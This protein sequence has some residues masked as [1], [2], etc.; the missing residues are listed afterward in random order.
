MSARVRPAK[1]LSRADNDRYVAAIEAK[2]RDLG[3]KDEAIAELRK[4]A[5]TSESAKVEDVKPRFQETLEARIK[6]VKDAGQDVEFTLPIEV[7]LRHVHFSAKAEVGKKPELR[8]V[9]NAN[10][11]GKIATRLRRAAGP[12][13]ELR[14]KHMLHDVSASFRPGSLTLVLGPPQ[15]GKTSLLRLC[16]GLLKPA[17]NAT[18]AAEEV[19]FNGDPVYPKITGGEK[20]FVPTKVSSYVDQIDRHAPSLTVEETLIFAWHTL[21]AKHHVNLPDRVP[22]VDD[23]FNPRARELNAGTVKPPK[24]DFVLNLLGIEHVR[25]TI[26]GNAVVRGVSGGQR[27]RVTIGEMFMGTARVLL[28]DE[29]STGLDSQT[30]FE[31]IRSFRLIADNFRSTMILS[32]LQPPPEVFNL[33]D[34]VALLWDGRVVY[35]GPTDNVVAH[36]EAIGYG[37]P[38]RKDVSDYLIEICSAVGGDYATSSNA[39][40]TPQALEDAWR[41]TPGHAVVAARL[42]T[43]PDKVDEWPEHFAKRFELP[44]QTYA[45]W[46]F[47][48]RLMEI[49]GDPSYYKA[50]A[51]Q[52]TF[53][54]LFTGS[55]YF[56]TSYDDFNN[57][58]G[59]FFVALLYIGLGAVSEVPGNIETRNMLYKHADQS[60]YPP[61]AYALAHVSFRVP[62]VVVESLVY[63]NLL[64]WLIGLTPGGYIGFFVIV[65]LLGLATSSIFNCVSLLAPNAAVATPI[66]GLCVLFFVLFSGF[67]V[68]EPAIPDGWIWM[69]WISPVAWAFR[70]VAVNEF[71]QDLYKGK[72]V[73]QEKGVCPPGSGR[74]CPYGSDG[75]FFLNAYGIKTERVWFY[76]GIIALA[77]YFVFFFALYVFLAARIRHNPAPQLQLSEYD[78]PLE[79]M[80]QTLTEEESSS[81]RRASSTISY[82]PTTLAFKNVKYTVMV[83]KERG[84]PYPLDLLQ[85]VTG[86][87]KPATLTALMGSSGAGKTTLLDVIAGRKTGGV[88]E[89]EITINGH[90]KDQKTFTRISGYVEQLDVHSPES[91]VYEATLFSATLR[92]DPKHAAKTRQF[93]DQIVSVLE[94]DDVRDRQIGALGDGD[95]LSFEQRKRLT[96]AVELAA[97]PAILFLDEP[98]SGLDS[99]AAIVVAR[100]VQSI[101][102]TGRSVICTIHQ[103]SYAL[104]SIFDRL[105]L[106]KKGGQTVYFGELGRECGDLTAYLSRACDDLATKAMRHELDDGVNPATWMLSACVAPEDFAAYYGA[107]ELAAE[108]VKL[109]AAAAEKAPGSEPVHFATLYALPFWNQVRVLTRRQ[110][111]NY[112]RSPSYNVTRGMVT[113]IV[114]VIFGTTFLKPR[115]G[116]VH[117]FSNSFSRCGLMY[118]DVFFMGIIFYSSAIPNM[119]SQRDSYYREYASRMYA[120]LPYAITFGIAEF[121]YLVLYSVLHVGL[122]WA[123][124]DFF[125]ANDGFLWYLFFF[126]LFISLL[127][128]MAQF[129]AAAMPNQQVASSLGMASR[130]GGGI[131]A[132]VSAD[133]LRRSDLSRRLDC[134]RGGR[135]ATDGTSFT[136]VVRPGT[137]PSRP[138]SR[139]S[140]SRPTTS[141]ASGA[142]CT[143]SRRSTTSSRASS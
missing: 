125:P 40:A 68:Q 66:S 17:G 3:V 58:L 22:G 76:Y 87:A 119:V 24:L 98:T 109:T 96:M 11:L 110:V 5:E 78:A 9:A 20:R 130:G 57:K 127:T 102:S 31:I 136:D 128:Y 54:G 75:A 106:L 4:T 126:F 42:A 117:D 115:P 77:S 14:D 135:T 111:T 83:S 30:T 94:L 93:V 121:P 19:S 56:N 81:K 120:A 88:V 134:S 28:G 29:I 25:D 45:Y 100:A 137:S 123:M 99:R 13:P 103:P 36:L 2:L 129:L 73:Y 85:G 35:H 27:R 6:A 49:K 79:E 113:I 59:A 53:M 74:S 55:L 48:R 105:L 122:L 141:P 51:I 92:L 118:L 41:A 12:A 69:Y 65:T 101:S 82:E 26:V 131:F 91:T 39:P 50:R 60:F 90:P 104:F 44:F 37:M 142:S 32:L 33:F 43:T 72:Q 46:C 140:P 8:T 67:V 124:V 38:A 21:G 84:E 138:T 86:Y 139:A 70:A 63:T 52:S 10:P 107:S 61:V 64:Y 116:A 71:T 34:D 7:R 15:A 132:R 23:T 97:N 80:P 1:T 108:N 16:G 112:Y 89:G 47:R 133:F 114:A 143:G 18:L 95:A 62:W